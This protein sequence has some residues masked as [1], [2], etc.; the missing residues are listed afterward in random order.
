MSKPQT[1][2]SVPLQDWRPSG[3]GHIMAPVTDLCVL[4]S[5]QRPRRLKLLSG[6]HRAGINAQAGLYEL[7]WENPGH[8]GS[9]CSCPW[10]LIR[11]FN[12]LLKY[13]NVSMYLW[14]ILNWEE[15]AVYSEQMHAEAM[16]TLR[17]KALWSGFGMLVG[18]YA[19]QE[20]RPSRGSSVTPQVCIYG[21][22]SLLQHRAW[23]LVSL[24]GRARNSALTFQSPARLIDTGKQSCPEVQSRTEEQIWTPTQ[25]LFSLLENI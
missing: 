16:Y 1:Y 5:A 6:D 17:A 15:M 19:A 4:L 11:N 22:W 25:W 20:A 24:N 13:K 21:L 14:N 23:A 8:P 7:L 12:Y 10:F 2:R 18:W 3:S 9:L